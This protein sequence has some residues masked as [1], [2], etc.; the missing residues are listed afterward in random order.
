MIRGHLVIVRRRLAEELA[1][2]GR[3]GE[4]LE[5]SRRSLETARGD[6]ELLYLLAGEYA[7]NAG[8]TG[9]TPTRL[10]ADQLRDRRR[11]FV[12]GAVAMLRQAV[13]DNFRD[14]AR[15]RSDPDFDPA[16]S[17]PEFAAIVAD[18]AFPVDPFAP[19]SARVGDPK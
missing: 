4:A 16:R 8:L 7:R 3:G 6:P 13:A 12:A 14:A 2:R 18:L 15:L 19:G 10:N 5:W 11:R 1:D 17:D 9:K